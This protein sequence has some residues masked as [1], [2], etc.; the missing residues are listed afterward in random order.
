MCCLF[1]DT[2]EI[3]RQNQAMFEDVRQSFRNYFSGLVP[4]RSADVL[5]VGDQLQEGVKFVISTTN[6]QSSGA[7]ACRSVDEL[8]GGQQALL[9][10]AFVFALGCHKPSS[11][12][13][14]DEVDAA[15]VR[16]QIHAFGCCLMFSSTL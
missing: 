14:L 9:G 3:Q 1:A 16:R 10:L 12:Y 15:L 2:V 11:M 8:S 6:G 5:P 7:G 4:G 13:L